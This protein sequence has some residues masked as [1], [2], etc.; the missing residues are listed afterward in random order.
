MNKDQQKELG[1]PWKR[2]GLFDTYEKA[3]KKKTE[4]L[5]DKDV[6]AKIK[7]FGQDGVQFQVK[8]RSISVPA[9][10][11]TKRTEKKSKQRSK[12]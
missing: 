7:R 2:A 10:K 4:I 1:R 12:N 3:L 9:A 6:E 11:K 5:D 8:F